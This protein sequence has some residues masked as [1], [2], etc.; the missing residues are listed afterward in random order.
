VTIRLIATLGQTLIGKKYSSRPEETW[1]RNGRRVLNRTVPGIDMILTDI[2][3]K[4]YQNLEEKL[5]EGHQEQGFGWDGTEMGM[6]DVIDGMVEGVGD[7]YGDDEENCL[8]EENADG[9]MIK[10]EIIG[11]EACKG[12][13]E[14]KFEFG[15]LGLNCLTH[16]FLGNLGVNKQETGIMRKSMCKQ[17]SPLPQ[18]LGGKNYSMMDGKRIPISVDPRRSHHVKI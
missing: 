6:K 5:Y 10:G 7:N 15:Y 9:M 4:A 17:R 18:K 1:T 11:K 2:D 8:D 13:I 3:A 16:E 14:S 12:W